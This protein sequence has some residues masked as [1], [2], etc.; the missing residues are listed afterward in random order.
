M[1]YAGMDRGE[2]DVEKARRAVQ[3]LRFSEA[4][5]MICRLRKDPG[6]RPHQPL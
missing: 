1:E 3:V 5:F 6:L 2:A 4:P